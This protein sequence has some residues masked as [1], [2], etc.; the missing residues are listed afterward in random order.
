LALNDELDNTAFQATFADSMTVVHDR[1]NGTEFLEGV[2]S[3][4]TDRGGVAPPAP[5]AFYE[6]YVGSDSAHAHLLYSYGVQDVFLVL[7]LA[8]PEERVVGHHRLD[9][10][11]EY[12]I[13]SPPDPTWF[14]VQPGDTGETQR[15]DGE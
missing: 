9:L 15:G 7:V 14:P 3:I 2:S 6:A 10:N 13:S 1:W 12:G 5:V 11:E 4:L 8:L